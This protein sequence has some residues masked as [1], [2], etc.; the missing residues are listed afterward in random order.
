MTTTSPPLVAAMPA[1]VAAGWPK[2]REKRSSLTRGSRSRSSRMRSS[3]ASGEG[4]SEKTIS[5]SPMPSSS[6]STGARRS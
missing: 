2:R 6:S 4:S 1:S 3:V 5:Q